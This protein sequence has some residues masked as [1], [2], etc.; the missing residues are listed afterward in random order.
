M[1]QMKERAV[2]LIERIPDEK[3]FYVINILQNLEEM[4][5]NRPADKKQA[6]EALQNVLKFSGRLPEDFDA[7]K[8]LQEAREITGIL[9]AHSI[10]NLFYILRKNFSQE[11]RRFLL[12]N[13]CEIFQISDLNEKKIV[14]ALENNA[15]SDFE[16]GLQE[17]CAV[18]SMADYIVTRNPADFK[19]SRVKVILPDEL[20][21]ELEKN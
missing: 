2:E 8:E 16:D 3:M 5:S 13:L 21:R 14:A 20:L 9:A 1:T 11:E 6:M 4:S 18:E 12:K 19:H 7:D 15:F 10:P 17:E